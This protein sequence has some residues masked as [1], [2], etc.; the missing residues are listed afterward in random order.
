[1]N[2]TV[3]LGIDHQQLHFFDAQGGRRIDPAAAG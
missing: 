3:P 1:M 2:E